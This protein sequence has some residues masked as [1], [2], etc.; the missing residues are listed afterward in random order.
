MV[1]KISL[2]SMGT[3]FVL[4]LFYVSTS[5]YFFVQNTQAL[6]S[7]PL[8]EK[9]S[10]NVKQPNII[11]ILTDDQD[12][13]LD[14][15]D[16]M[17][18]LKHYFA[19]EGVRFIN[20]FAT[21]PVCCPSRSSILTGQYIHNINVFNNSLSGGCCSSD[22]IKESSPKDLSRHLFSSVLERPLCLFK[23]IERS[24][25]LIEIVFYQT[26]IKINHL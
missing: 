1:G 13:V 16:Y 22:W 8:L 10:N 7:F 17:P 15:V 14:S 20:A 26:N 12:E 4:F 18:N 19:E 2:F 25:I 9:D 11:L 5:L 23:S 21:T 24:S 6:H 3:R